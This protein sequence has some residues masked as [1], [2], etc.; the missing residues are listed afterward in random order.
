MHTALPAA[1]PVDPLRLV[2][3]DPADV[4]DDELA[5]LTALDT[6]V[7]RELHPSPAPAVPVDKLGT[8]RYGWDGQPPEVYVAADAAD[9]ARLTAPVATLQLWAPT[10][11]NRTMAY[12]D[13]QVHA[14]HRRRG[15][16]SAL[17][18]FGEQRA[19]EL[20]R[21]T[22]GMDYRADD[23]AGAAFA[24]RHGYRPVLQE[25]WRRLELADLDR[26]RLTAAVT[27]AQE[28]AHGYELLR[29][30]GPLPADLLAG[31]ANI[32]MTLNDAPRDESAHEDEV[33]T[34]ARIRA[35]EL[36]RAS[37]G[38]RLY[39]VL[40]R[41]RA[42]GQLAGH[43]LLGTQPA[44]PGHAEQDTTGVAR[45]HRGHRLGLLLK[46]EML[47]W[48]TGPGGPERQLAH[49]DTFNAG[50]NTHMTAI[51]DLLGF[52]VMAASWQCEKT[53]T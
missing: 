5:A 43:T 17:V 15:L 53:L 12:L 30:A 9:P 7:Q 14:D 40:A 8:Y 32:E 31:S 29:I 18:A 42:D 25:V 10:Y 49:V 24:R 11:D 48:L 22:I 16:G 45:D 41:R 26:E 51:N 1:L 38:W 39:R 50:S 19:R 34:P 13:V 28:H 36:A 52:K 27:E 2:R 6:A 20:G 23:P 46:V 21:G 47:T 44:V 33:F 3:L 37:S 4:S 35:F